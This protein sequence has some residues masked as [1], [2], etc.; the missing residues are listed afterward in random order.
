M[1]LFLPRNKM[2]NKPV[3][4]YSRKADKYKEYEQNRINN[5]PLKKCKQYGKDF[6]QYRKF[7]QFCSRD[8]AYKNWV[9]TNK[10]K[11][12]NNPGFR[13]GMY[14][15]RTKRN[16][17]AT[18]HSNACRKYRNNFRKNNE[19][20]YCE[21]CGVSNSLRF[22]AHHIIFASEA[23]KH[24]ELHNFKNLILLCIEC[25]NELHKHKILRNK[26]VEERGLNKLFGRNLTTYDKKTSN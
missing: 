5:S 17:T 21:R 22:E 1:T 26:L 9:E 7:L 3:S 10:R 11:G 12:V 20:D 25:H 13:N 4:Y 24:K 23:P 8:C 14:V 15:N 16:E 2:K 19:Y 6:K 18:I